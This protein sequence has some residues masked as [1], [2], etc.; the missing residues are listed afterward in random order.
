MFVGIL[1]AS[2]KQDFTAF[3]D[4]VFTRCTQHLKDHD[5]GVLVTSRDHE[6]TNFDEANNGC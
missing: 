2:S 6:G 4:C 5:G 3:T 1:Q